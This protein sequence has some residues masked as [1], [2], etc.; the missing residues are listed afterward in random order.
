MLARGRRTRPAAARQAEAAGLEQQPDDRTRRVLR[1]LV[2]VGAGVADRAASAVSA[3]VGN[4][5]DGHVAGF[6]GV[7]WGISLGLEGPQGAGQSAVNA[8]PEGVRVP[9]SSPRRRS[10]CRSCPSSLELNRRA[11]RRCTSRAPRRPQQ[12]PI[13]PRAR[14]LTEQRLDAR[15]GLPS[16]VAGPG[17][18]CDPTRLGCGRW[19]R[20]QYG[21]SGAG[22]RR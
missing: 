13:P 1:L 4:G 12:R 2:Q 17:G 19:R 10:C 20:G 3:V 21:A 16:L 15:G 11:A 8:G 22:N 18:G 14:R 9:R 6:R 7:P 5:F